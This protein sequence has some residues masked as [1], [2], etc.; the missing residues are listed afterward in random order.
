MAY[1]TNPIGQPWPWG[2]TALT[3]Q[4]PLSTKIG[5]NFADK[6][7]SLGIVHLWTKAMDFVFVLLANLVWTF[8]P[9]GSLSSV[10]S[11][12]TQRSV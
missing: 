12:P 3:T 10:M 8:L 1:L 2:S 4:R 6:Q 9:S 11:L 7:W 5:T